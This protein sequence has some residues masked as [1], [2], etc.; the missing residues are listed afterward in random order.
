[1]DAA[2]RGAA[3][4]VRAQS[5]EAYRSSVPSPDG[6]LPASKVL[7]LGVYRT[8]RDHLQLIMY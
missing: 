8:P 6:L 3:S 7:W 5:S 4:A 2:I 1:M